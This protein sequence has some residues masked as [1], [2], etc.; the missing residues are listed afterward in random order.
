MSSN[1]R[2]AGNISTSTWT[3][4]LIQTNMPTRKC[5][6]G[7]EAAR[8]IVTISPTDGHHRFFFNEKLIEALNGINHY[9]LVTK[10]RLAFIFEWGK[11]GGI[12]CE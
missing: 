3:S 4:R 10:V 12:R 8:V 6:G 1:F 7:I 2:R 5:S 11:G 9:G